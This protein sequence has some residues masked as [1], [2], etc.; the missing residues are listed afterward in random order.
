MHIQILCIQIEKP[1]YTEQLMVSLFIS[2]K[3]VA[4]LKT[5]FN[6]ECKVTIK[7]QLMQTKYGALY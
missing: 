1:I 6:Y 5:L 7:Q 2:K 4:K 3:V